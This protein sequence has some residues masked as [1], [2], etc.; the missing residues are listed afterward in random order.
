MNIFIMTQNKPIS[1]I[2]SGRNVMGEEG[3]FYS[4]YY[5]FTEWHC[6][7]S[8]LFKMRLNK[9]YSETFHNHLNYFIS[10][11]YSNYYNLEENALLDALD[12]GI[13]FPAPFSKGQF[14]L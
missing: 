6:S 10:A 13:P 11:N 9:S 14:N 5:A 8:Q 4:A 1:S 7:H 12:N 2:F 3:L